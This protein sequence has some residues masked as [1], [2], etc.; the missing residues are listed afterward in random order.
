[1]SKLNS[2]RNPDGIW[3]NT[4][5]FMETGAYFV[6]NGYYCP[7]PEE[8]PDWYAFWRE[9]R[10]RIMGG[11]TCGG[12]KITG[13]HYYY[14]NFCQIE[15][16]K[17][18]GGGLTKKFTAFP[19]F[20]DGDFNYFWVRE[21]ARFGA[22]SI[23][24]TEEQKMKLFSLGDIDRDIENVK[25]YNSL[26]LEIKID[27]KDLFGNHNLIV[28]KARRRG[29]S[30]KAAAVA[31]RNFYTQPNKLTI[32]AAY[33][34]KYLYPEGIFS[35]ADAN[36]DFMNSKTAFRTPSDYI[37]RPAQGHIRASYKEITNGIETEEG[38][39]SD[40][41]ALSFKDN[42]DAARG[43]DAL[44]FFFEE[45]GAFG[46]PG[47]L[48]KSYFASQDCVRAGLKKTGMITIFGTSGDLESGTADYADMFERPAAFGLLPMKNIWDQ[49]SEDQN[50]G[51]FHPI[52]WNLEGFYDKN[53]NS[54]KNAAKAAIIAER[55][56][57]IAAGATS[58]ELQKKLQELPLGPKEAFGAVSINNF[59]TLELKLRR[60]EVKAKNLQNIMATPIE[61]YYDKGVATAKVLLKNEAIPITSLTNLPSNKQGCPII[62][63]FP[64]SNSEKGL[65]KIGYDPVRQDNGTS[66]A[67]IVVYKGNHRGS[68]SNNIIVAEY[69][70]RKNTTEDIDQIAVFFA[71]Y[72]NTRVMY[73]N[74]VPGFKNFC[75][76]HK[77]MHLLAAQPDAVISKNIKNSKTQRVVGC[78]MNTQLKD[79]GER[80]TKDW[81]LT[82]LDYDMNQKPITVIDK[83]F[84][85]RMLDECISYSPKGNFDLISAFFMCIF[86]VQ[87]ES[88]N[89]EYSNKK[90]GS[91]FV[92]LRDTLRN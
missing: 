25:L 68:S 29:Y 38:L 43:K 90:R 92:E 75:R 91:R 72:Y 33:E 79:A 18:I 19:D 65:Y 3:I 57:K 84:S 67:A 27:K 73:E 56:E 88:L 34:K 14:L 26:K 22:S 13:T 53:G 50:C 59:P 62:Y 2:I 8:S 30:L 16:A 12:V 82:V 40:I 24:D 35:F 61:F 55:D 36:K 42:A 32:F 6:A 41:M 21:V 5:V 20:W 47:L 45:S 23:L 77:K 74:E 81:L 80:Y 37:N 52:N 1:M 83:I 64:I 11:Y 78:H 46:P 28:G 85:I 70:G 54:D 9:E 39:K 66:L 89:K 7:D 15:K 51:F 10:K 76:R 63:E 87:E 49:D 44:D 86:Q 48:Q 31:S 4:S 71:E 60:S 17:D 58:A 69:I